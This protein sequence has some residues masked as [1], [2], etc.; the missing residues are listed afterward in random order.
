MQLAT[1]QGLAVPPF[2]KEFMMPF[3]RYEVQSLADFSSRLPRSFRSKATA[4]GLHVRC[5]QKV[6]CVIFLSCIITKLLSPSI[7]PPFSLFLVILPLILL[8]LPPPHMPPSRDAP[9]LDARKHRRVVFQGP[10]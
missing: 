8:L 9:Q 10:L 4:E 6:F 3:T 2:L 1:L 7:L 5:F